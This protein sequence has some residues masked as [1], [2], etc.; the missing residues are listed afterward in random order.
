MDLSGLVDE[1]GHLASDETEERVDGRKA[2][3][4]GC[5]GIATL[6]FE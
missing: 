5:D 2:L 1:L 3:V 6:L 4:S